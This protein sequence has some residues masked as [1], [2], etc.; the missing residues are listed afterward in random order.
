MFIKPYFCCYQR[1][2]QSDVQNVKQKLRR[3]FP[4][5]IGISRLAMKWIEQDILM[6]TRL[7]QYFQSVGT[8]QQTLLLSLLWCNVESRDVDFQK[9]PRQVKSGQ[10]KKEV[11]NSKQ[12]KEE[13]ESVSLQ[14]EPRRY[15]Q[16]LMV[17]PLLPYWSMEL[18][19][20]V[21]RL[22]CK[23]VV[24]ERQCEPKT[25]PHSRYLYA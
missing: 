3:V 18:Q 4:T 15:A 2:S 25:Q 1:S 10:K 20:K 17:P 11:A 9:L 13:R 23:A 7:K 19:P 12:H 8:A 14:V 6:S 22:K 16:L 5:T 21:E 24:V